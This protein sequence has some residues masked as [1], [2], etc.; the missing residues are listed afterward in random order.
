MPKKQRKAAAEVWVELEKETVRL[1]E[2][3]ERLEKAV[4]AYN[5][6]IIPWNKK[7]EEL[8]ACREEEGLEPDINEKLKRIIVK[9]EVRHYV[10]LDWWRLT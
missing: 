3:C 10:S 9:S 2:V 6:S 8:K 1:N 4:A 5:H 7:L